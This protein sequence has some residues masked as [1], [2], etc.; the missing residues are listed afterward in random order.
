MQYSNSQRTHLHTECVE[1]RILLKS[2]AVAGDSD[3]AI[4]VEKATRA[5]PAED[6]Y[7][8]ASAPP[9]GCASASPY[10]KEQAS[11]ASPMGYG[12]STDSP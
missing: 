5:E 10:R 9:C 8:V 11:A 1:S 6:P 2:E 7:H 12:T 4:P 3:Q